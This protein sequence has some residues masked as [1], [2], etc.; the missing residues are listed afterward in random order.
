MKAPAI[1]KFLHALGC[2]DASEQGEWVTCK[3]PLAFWRHKSG[4]DSM[5][6]FG[7]NIEKGGF[8]CFACEKGSLEYLIG[9]L[10]LYLSKPN[11]PEPLKYRYNIPLAREILSDAL[12]DL[13]VLDPYEDALKPSGAVFNPWPDWALQGF[14]PAHLV[15]DSSEYLTK[16]GVSLAECKQFDLR[17][18]TPRQMLL[19]PYKNV[20]GKLAGIRGRS[21]NPDANLQH[22]DYSTGG[23]KNAGL[24]FFNEQVIPEAVSAHMPLL[25]VEG[26]FDTIAVS[27][28]YP[29]VLGN[30]TAK[31]THEKIATL[32]ACPDGVLLM[33]DNDETGIAST[34][35]WLKELKVPKGKLEFPAQYKDPDQI[36]PAELAEL[37]APLLCT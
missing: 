12:S 5:P 35:L 9:I 11:L 19:A 2:K 21:I 4:K 16:R 30:L 6:S 23:A 7:V 36:P 31:P 27:R 25:V 13:D 10:S 34:L 37:V 26:Q 1:I 29:Y 8:N 17:F 22:Y 14:T 20:W 24:V 15:H 3:C 33:L 28:H 32:N 18:D